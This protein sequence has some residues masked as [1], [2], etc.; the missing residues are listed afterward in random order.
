MWAVIT[1]VD[2]PFDNSEL[3]SDR[4]AKD[5]IF[6]SV[7]TDAGVLSGSSEERICCRL[8]LFSPLLVDG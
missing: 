4:S 2:A 5:D 8:L 7:H 3:E 1:A 6:R